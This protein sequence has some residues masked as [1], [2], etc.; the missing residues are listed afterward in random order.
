[1]E[2]F[3]L[4]VT[5]H[6]SVDLHQWVSVSELGQ[7]DLIGS[8][9]RQLPSLPGDIVDRQDD[10]SPAK[11][12]APNLAAVVAPTRHQCAPRYASITR[13][14]LRITSGAPSASSLPW[15]RQ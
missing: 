7:G 8:V 2:Y 6:Q 12:I 11:A 4:A 1:M 5:G 13:W 10:V 3:H 15:A 14:S 9:L